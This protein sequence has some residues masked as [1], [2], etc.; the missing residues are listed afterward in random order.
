MSSIK[1]IDKNKKSILIKY[2][3]RSG[4]NWFANHYFDIEGDIC[5]NTDFDKIIPANQEQAALI[6]FVIKN[7]NTKG[8]EYLS[9]FNKLSFEVIEAEQKRQDMTL[10][11]NKTDEELYNIISNFI[12]NNEVKFDSIDSVIALLKHLNQDFTLALECLSQIQEDDNTFSIFNREYLILTDSEADDRA[13]EY[14]RDDPQTFL[15][16]GNDEW[17]R[18]QPYFDEDK[19]VEACLQ[20]GR[21]RALASYDDREF[22]YCIKLAGEF[23]RYYIYRTN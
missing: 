16:L 15:G 20:D 17:S 10:L 5:R 18:V 1:F 22:E 21:G 13:D 11:N 14:Y 4:D 12:E 2:D 8:S 19:F 23:K 7:H 3:F 6:N 9:D